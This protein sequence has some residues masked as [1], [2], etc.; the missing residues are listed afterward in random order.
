M[1]DIF[2]KKDKT[3]HIFVFE[4]LI[5]VISLGK[6]DGRTLYLWIDI[7]PTEGE[8]LDIS[9]E[10]LDQEQIKERIQ[11]ITEEIP[12]LKYKQSAIDNFFKSTQI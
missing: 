9:H 7:S 1:H 12:G 2:L 6:Y 11:L 4:S 10:Q 5:K 8:Y 3:L